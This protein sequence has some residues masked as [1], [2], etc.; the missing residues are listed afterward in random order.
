MSKRARIRI[1]LVLLIGAFAGYGLATGQFCPWGRAQSPYNPQGRPVAGAPGA[2]LPTDRTVLPIPE[3]NYPHSDVLDARNAKAPPR[4]EV[5][6][7]KRRMPD[8]LIDDMGLAIERSADRS[9]CRR[10]RNWRRGLSYSQFH[11]TPSARP[12]GPP[13]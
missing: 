2:D 12:P 3:P 4:F 9:T 6:A 10:S 7:P 11:T 13:C 5:K 1:A 8:C